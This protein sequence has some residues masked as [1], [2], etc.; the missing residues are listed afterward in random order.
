[1]RQWFFLGAAG[2]VAL[3]SQKKKSPPLFSVK[4]TSGANC[5]SPKLKLLGREFEKRQSS[6]EEI[7][8]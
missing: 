2:E 5:C 3:P 1:M 7:V 6:F 8:P 4:K